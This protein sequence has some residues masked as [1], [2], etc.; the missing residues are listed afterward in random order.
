MI[1]AT[2]KDHNKLDVNMIFYYMCGLFNIFVHCTYSYISNF[3]NINFLFKLNELKSDLPYR[4]TMKYL[5][6][7]NFI[8][9]F[10]LF[11]LFLLAIQ[12]FTPGVG[13][14]H[15]C[16]PRAP[17]QQ[18]IYILKTI[19]IIFFVIKTYPMLLIQ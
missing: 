8:I 6:V 3:H 4:P 14:L 9:L 10:L 16:G 18:K 13:K 5:A 2:G 17:F 12:Y 11:Y 1:I 19:K 15:K 7:M